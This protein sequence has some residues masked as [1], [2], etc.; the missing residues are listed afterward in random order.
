MRGEEEGSGRR[1]ERQCTSG[2]SASLHLPDPRSASQIAPDPSP[3]DLDHQVK[4][5]LVH[6]LGGGGV[7]A[8]HVLPV[9]G[10]VEEHVLAGGEAKLVRRVGL[11]LVMWRRRV[12]GASV[13]CFACA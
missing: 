6:V 9:D 11:G 7:G 12:G 2:G 5:A 13:S 8:H 4:V 10:G 1:C 3:V